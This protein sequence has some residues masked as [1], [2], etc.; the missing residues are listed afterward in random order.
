MAW[1]RAIISG[2]AIG[3]VACSSGLNGGREDSDANANLSLALTGTD[4]RGVQYRL[5]SAEFEIYGY[6]ELVQFGAGGAP[7]SFFSTVVSSETDPNAAVIT[8]RVIPGY[9]YVDFTS[10]DWFLE[11]LTPSGP[12]RVEQAVLLSPRLQ[13]APVWN[14]GSTRVHYQFGVDGELIDFRSGNIN[15]GIG[16]ERPGDSAGAGGD[17]PVVSGGA[18]GV[19]AVD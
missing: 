6:P 12:E 11:E 17:G 19:G 16:I 10:G 3:I 1:A 8:Q 4:S 2:I 7:D 13:F 9:Y 15:I 18:G 14:G 5:R